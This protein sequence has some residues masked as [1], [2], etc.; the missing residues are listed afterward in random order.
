MQLIQTYMERDFKVPHSFEHYVYVSQL[1]QAYGIKK[2]LEAH[3][4]AKPY[5]MGTLY[6]QLND[7]WPAISWSSVDYYN[8]WKALHYFTKKTFKDFLISF[9]ENDGLLN[10]FVVSDRLASVEAEL[11]MSIL[12]FKGEDVWSEKRTIEISANSSKIYEELSLPEI[13]KGN[14]LIFCKLIIDGEVLA[15]NIYY[16]EPPKDLLLPIPDIQKEINR[17]EDGYQITLNTNKLAK[18]IFLSIPVDGHFSDNYFDLLPGEEKELLFKGSK[19][20]NS[21]E[22]ELK[23]ISLKDTY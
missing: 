1:V 4:R 13:S 10:V 21:F 19:P 23:V 14:H 20:I 5:C 2:A 15:S 17:V 6:W 11:E 7:C 12:D 18:N 16:F 22:K 9:E 3:R 8:R